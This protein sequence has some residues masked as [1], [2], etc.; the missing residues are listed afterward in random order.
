MVS[1]NIKCPETARQA[2]V[3]FSNIDAPLSQYKFSSEEKNWTV[4]LSWLLSQKPII[5]FLIL[6]SYEFSSNHIMIYIISYS[7]HDI[8]TSL[9][10]PFAVKIGLSSKLAPYSCWDKGYIAVIIRFVTIHPLFRS[11]VKIKVSIKSCSS[12]VFFLVGLFWFFSF[13]KQFLSSIKKWMLWNSSNI[14]MMFTAPF[15]ATDFSLIHDK[16]A[17]KKSGTEEHCI[18]VSGK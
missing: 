5:S 1:G 17:M 10:I 8:R 13:F 4:S 12:T 6:T 16:K 15:F 9:K 3:P 11:K 2:N 18:G 14:S 7:L